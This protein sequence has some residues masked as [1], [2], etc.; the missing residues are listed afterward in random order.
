MTTTGAWADRSEQIDLIS[1]AL[2]QA[3]G[4]LSDLP[5]TQTANTGKYAYSYATLA[6]A[7]AQA[8]PVL[9]KHGLAITQTASTT[10]DDVLIH[11]TI[12]HSSGQFITSQP[13]AMPVGQTAQAT[14][15]SVTYG[16]RYSLM[17]VLGL[18]TEDDDGA[19][20]SHREARRTSP[21]P[22]AAQTPVSL[23]DEPRTPEEAKIR[24]MLGSV[25]AAEAK[26]LKQAFIETFG[27]GLSDLDPSLH[28]SALV[29]VE[30]SI[31]WDADV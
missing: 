2:V 30:A 29:W 15:S 8:R 25:P 17:A 20:A 19:T 13:I 18:A 6:D 27:S 16:R 4:E 10:A 1:S 14:G 9:L 11:T 31:G 7:L 5:K 3:L 23:P 21:A 26:E 28:A 12:L 24:H 22:R